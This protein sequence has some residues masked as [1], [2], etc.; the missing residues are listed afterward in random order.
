MCEKERRKG[1]HR[2]VCLLRRR[3]GVD[4]LPLQLVHVLFGEV[5][6]AP[7][8]PD[9][10][11]LGRFVGT[12]AIGVA[13]VVEDIRRRLWRGRLLL[14]RD[15]EEHREKQTQARALFLFATSSVVAVVP[16]RATGEHSRGTCRGGIVR[17]Y[18]MESRRV[19]V[20]ETRW[21]GRND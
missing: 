19:L 4:V 1:A 14:A 16:F 7:P 12:V 17:G 15:G 9:S 11:A 18:T 3:G 20:L 21:W 13:V 8:L 10:A 6:G 5:Y 2:R